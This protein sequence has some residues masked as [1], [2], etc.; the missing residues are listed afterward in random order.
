MLNKNYSHIL[1]VTLFVLFA[2]S[3]FSFPK[4]NKPKNIILL[5]GDGMGLTTV[6]TSIL[7]DPESVFRKFRFIGLSVTC[8]ADNLITDSAAGA[9]ALSAGERTNNHYVG[10]DPQSKVLQNIFENAKKRNYS[11]GIVAT[12]SITHATPAAFYA[13]IPERSSE[14]KI[15]EQF[16]DSGIDVAIGGGRTFFLPENKSGSRQDD[17]DLIQSLDSKDYAC[18]NNIEDLRKYNGNEKVIGLLEDASLKEASSRNYS[19]GDLTNIAINRLS[20]NEKGFILMVEGSQIDWGAH[21]NK[22][23][24]VHSEL[25]DFTKAIKAALDF[26]DKDGNTLVIVTADHE[27]GGVAITGGEVNKDTKLSFASKGH[28]AA[29]VGI[30]SYG[31]S[32]E[33]FQGVLENKQI[34]KN[35]FYLINSE[36]SSK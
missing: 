35:L 23:E 6:S 25:S 21:D 8:S 28:T 3:S 29:C 20:K 24:K 7:S 14:F 33:M 17:L 2:V 13:H 4:D 5:I 15:A 9:T 22:A 31:P 30:F 18:F 26:A 36:T 12:S 11:T 16:L 1:V 32:A 10:V 27:T 34:G 19:L